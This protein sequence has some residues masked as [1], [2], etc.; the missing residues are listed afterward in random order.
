MKTHNNFP[1]LFADGR[2]TGKL[3]RLPQW[4]PSVR[5]SLLRGVKRR[6]KLVN[7]LL[8]KEKFLS[9]PPD[10]KACLLVK[11]IGFWLC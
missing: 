8:L 3:S 2:P 1:C 10:D 9:V 4:G 11:K 5:V 6:S 7:L